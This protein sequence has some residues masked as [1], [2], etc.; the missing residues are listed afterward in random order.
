MHLGK[1]IKDG[2]GEKKTMMMMMMVMT[3]MS[4][5]TDVPD[6]PSVL[7]SILCLYSLKEYMVSVQS[8]VYGIMDNQRRS[9]FTPKA[10]FC[11][12]GSFYFMFFCAVNGVAFGC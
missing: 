9:A 8:E 12:S 2:H 7:C 6:R 11:T 1:K 3:V 4:G 10:F 5:R